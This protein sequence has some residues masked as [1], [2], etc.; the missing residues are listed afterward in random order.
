[1]M[2][3]PISILRNIST[4][5]MIARRNETARPTFRN[6]AHNTPETARKACSDL[7]TPAGTRTD[8]QTQEQNRLNH[9]PAQPP[10]GHQSP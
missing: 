3:A 10:P 7:Q 9:P 5:I 4:R 1:M 2:R 8:A 6:P